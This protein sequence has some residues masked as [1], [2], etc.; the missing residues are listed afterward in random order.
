LNARVVGTDKR[1]GYRVERVIYESRPNHH[2]TAALYL[3]DA[4]PPFPGVLL[5]CGHS[6]NGKA[7]EPYQRACI[8]LA[9]NGMAVLCFDPIGQGERVLALTS[10][11]RAPSAGSTPEHTLSG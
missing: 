5:P 6:Q 11:R 3:P 7:A 2:V 1:D 8:L 9:R 10:R 4:A